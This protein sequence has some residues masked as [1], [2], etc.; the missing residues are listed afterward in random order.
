MPSQSLLQ[1]WAVT[2]HPAP[3]RRVIDMETALLQQLL[4]I[5]QRKRIAKIPPGRTTYKAGF[6]L[7]P[8]E[9]RGSG[10]HLRDSSTSTA[11]SPGSCN[12]SFFGIP[13]T[14]KAVA[15]LATNFYRLSVGQFVDEHDQPDLLGL[16]EIG[17]VPAYG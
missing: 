15:V 3:N 2:L 10:Y 17:P 5:A 11:S 14:R 1:L 8:F 6:G 9:D 4:D 13:P 12:T 7:P 16:Q